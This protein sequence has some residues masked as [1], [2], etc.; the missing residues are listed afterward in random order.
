ME[1][2]VV[3][4]ILQG[5]LRGV[6]DSKQLITDIS[7]A[8]NN[9]IVGAGSG[10]ATLLLKVL[11]GEFPILH[12]FMTSIYPSGEHDVITL[13]YNGILAMKGF[14]E[15]ADC[16][17]I[18]LMVSSGELGTTIRPKSLVTSSSGAFWKQHQKPFDAMNIVVANLLLKLTR[19]SLTPLHTLADVNIPT[20]RFNHLIQADPKHSLDFACA[21]MVRRNVQVSELCRNTERL[22]TS[23][24]FGPSGRPFPL[25]ALAHNTYMKPTFMEDGGKPFHGT[26]SSL[27]GLTEEYNQLDATKSM[28]VEDLLRLSIAV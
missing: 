21:L 20:Q 25:L 18:D 13:P 26:V 4:E 9:W 14:N 6:F 23:L 7:G 17:K 2:A 28:P 12:R 11:E 5:P 8:G 1:E 10:L 22:R 27:L 19:S 24:V 15:H 16:V 3:C